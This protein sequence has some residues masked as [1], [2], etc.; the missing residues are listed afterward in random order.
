MKSLLP[1]TFLCLMLNVTLIGQTLTPEQLQTDFARFRTALNEVHPEMYRYTPKHTFDSLFT[2]TSARLNR[3]MTQHEFYVTMMPLLTAL[4]DGHIKWIVSGKDEHYPFFTDKLFP[5]KLYFLDEKAWVVGNYG[6]G[7]VPDGAEITTINGKSTASLIQSLLPNMTFADGNRI[8]GKL[9]DLNR[10]FS[11]YYATFI[12]APDAFAVTYRMGNEE[13]NVTLQPVTE[14]AI[15]AYAEKHKSA[16]QHPLR[17]TFVDNQTAVMT[18]EAFFKEMNGLKFSQFLQKS[19]REIKTKGAQNL[20]LDLRDNE[21]GEES[22]GVLLY[23]YLTNQPFR[24]YDHISVRQKKRYSFPAWTSKLYRLAKFMVVKKRGD[25]Y[26]FTAQRGLSIT[27]PQKDAYSGKLYE[28]L[29]G[30]SFSVTTEFAARAHADKRAQPGRAVFIGQES[31]GGYKLN[32]SGIFTITQLPNSK[33]DLGIGMFGFHMA[34]VS[35]YPHADRGIIP[36]YLVEPTA[37]DILT[38]KDRV[39]DYTLKLIQSQQSALTNSR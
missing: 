11:G 38:H 16:P 8:G 28:L 4:R 33:I 2:A 3:P 5:L 17:L 39:M 26:V 37:D 12:G 36:D 18:I 21:G 10:Y 32:S 6:A 15:K 35:A 14:Q 27:K 20:V 34:N 24:Y 22:L 31:G 23:S 29:N 9:E 19:F 30:N 1:I 13:T 7:N 25:G